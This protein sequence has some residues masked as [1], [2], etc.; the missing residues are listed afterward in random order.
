MLGDIS[1]V[2]LLMNADRAKKALLMVNNKDK[3]ALD[4]C[5]NDYLKARVEGREESR[6][7]NFYSILIYYF[8]ID[9]MRKLGI[10]AKPRISL[11]ER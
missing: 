7:K 4:L 1:I 8:C 5:K 10:F 6:F 11:V 3:K 2:K 9:V